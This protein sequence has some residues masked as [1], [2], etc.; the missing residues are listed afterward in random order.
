M[1]A[2]IGQFGQKPLGYCAGNLPLSAA[3][4]YGRTTTRKDKELLVG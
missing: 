1:P 3:S 2:L 4:R